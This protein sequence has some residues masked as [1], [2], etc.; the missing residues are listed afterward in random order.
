[1]IKII[2]YLKTAA[3]LPYCRLKVEFED[4]V[5]GI[6]DLGKWKEKKA[7]AFWNDEKS[8]SSFKITTDKKIEWMANVDMDPDAFY[9]ELVNKTF[10][11]YASDKQLL[12][13]S[14]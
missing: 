3:A 13:H 1:M 10:E 5:N 7:F 2:P 6:I 8:F 12:R 11:K 4:G 14:H 9:L